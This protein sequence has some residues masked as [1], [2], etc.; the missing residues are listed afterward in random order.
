MGRETAVVWRRMLGTS[1]TTRGAMAS[2]RRS[3]SPRGQTDG[4]VAAMAMRLQARAATDW[5]VAARRMA[6]R[7][8]QRG[9]RG[10]GTNQP[11]RPRPVHTPWL[12]GTTA[13]R[14]VSTPRAEQHPAHAHLVGEW[15]SCPRKMSRWKRCSS[16]EAFLVARCRV[17]A[18]WSW[19]EAMTA[20][21]VWSWDQMMLLT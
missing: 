19:E 15:K 11:R 6:T 20:C 18:R 12:L 8:T 5:T 10:A 16:A 1:A 14:P 13:C 3:C 21:R 4:G 17:K 7:R 2:Q 9:H